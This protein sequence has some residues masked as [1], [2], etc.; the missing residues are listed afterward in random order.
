MSAG[1]SAKVL[2]VLVVVSVVV[3]RSIPVPERFFFIGVVVAAIVALGFY[4]DRNLRRQ[5]GD[6]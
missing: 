5:A 6:E 2:V 3:G 1:W 4:V